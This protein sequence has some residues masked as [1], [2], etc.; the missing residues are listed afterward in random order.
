MCYYLHLTGKLSLRKARDLPKDTGSEGRDR[1]PGQL[2]LAEPHRHC[3][4]GANC[5]LALEW[6]W[7]HLER[8]R[9]DA[10]KLCKTGI[11]E[12]YRM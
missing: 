1:T 5:Q 4:H 12:K 8:L 6:L 3:L 11:P 10:L 9:A 2:G 7:A